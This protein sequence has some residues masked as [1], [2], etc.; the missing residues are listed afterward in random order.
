VLLKKINMARQSLG[1]HEL[2]ASPALKGV[3]MGLSDTDA[4]DLGLAAEIMLHCELI[5]AF[6]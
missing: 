6:F 2:Q 3:G 1:A 4:F 5:L